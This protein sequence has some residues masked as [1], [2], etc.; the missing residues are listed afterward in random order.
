M[1][2]RG[3]RPA[4]F[5]QGSMRTRKVTCSVNAQLA[6]VFIFSVSVVQANSFTT[7]L[8]CTFYSMKRKLDVNIDATVSFSKEPHLTS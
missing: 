1:I 4:T 2:V 3:K 8:Y 7:T 5:T 6:I